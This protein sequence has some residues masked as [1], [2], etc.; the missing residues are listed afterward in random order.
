MATKQHHKV[1]R[2]E[3]SIERLEQQLKDG[4]RTLST[5]TAKKFS[6]DAKQGDVVPLSDEDIKRIKSIIEN[7]KSNIRGG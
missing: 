3:S 1:R 2:Q 7:T 6:G 4:T 5:R